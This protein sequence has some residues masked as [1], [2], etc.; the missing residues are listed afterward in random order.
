MADTSAFGERAQDV[1]QEDGEMRSPLA[2]LFSN[3][4]ATELPSFEVAVSKLIADHPNLKKLAKMAMKKARKVKEYPG[5]S[6]DKKS[7]VVFYSME[8]YPSSI[9]PYAILNK[10]LREK[11]LCCEAVVRLH[12]VVF[13][14]ATRNRAIVNIDCCSRVQ[15]ARQ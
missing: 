2:G 5:M 3:Y 10:A 14:R 11:N 4:S 6:Q 13:A 8:D 1:G 9:S 7:S 12:L 15:A